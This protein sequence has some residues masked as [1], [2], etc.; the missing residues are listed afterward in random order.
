MLKTAN[1]KSNPKE[2]AENIIKNLPQV[3][4]FE[5]VSDCCNISSV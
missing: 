2:V 5:K 3:E 1:V 4:Y